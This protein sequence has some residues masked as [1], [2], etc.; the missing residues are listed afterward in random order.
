M[1]LTCLSTREFLTLSE[2]SLNRV[3]VITGNE[4]WVGVTP[5]P[6][7][8]NEQDT[9]DLFSPLKHLGHVNIA[10]NYEEY[11]IIISHIIMRSASCS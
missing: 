1:E 5:A 7:A 9:F 6:V 11:S 10:R 8:L 2:R 3:I 4:G